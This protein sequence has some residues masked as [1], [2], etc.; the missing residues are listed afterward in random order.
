M[1]LSR[2]RFV[3]LLGA[4]TAASLAAP[5]AAAAASRGLEARFA[6]RG[7]DG[8]PGP[9]DDVIRLDSN[10]NPNGPGRA[11]LDALAGAAAGAHRYPFAAADAL[12][13]AVARLHGADAANV[14]VCCGSTDVLRACV[15][16]FA[17]PGRALVTAAPTFETPAA[18]AALAGA[19]VTAVP[20]RADLRLD[21][22]AMAAAA[23]RGAGLV[24][25]CNP[26]NPTGTVHG[27]DA[28]RALVE[29][30]LREA[31]GCAVVV[32]EA[33]HE[34]V[35]DS[36]YATAVPLA[37][38]HPRVVVARTFSKVYGLAGARVGYA[39]A[40]ADTMQA[41]APRALDIGVNA[42]G[43]AAALATLGD[44]AHLE[45]ERARNRAAR[46]YT[47]RFFA[48]AGYAPA[49]SEANFLMVDL[50]RDAGPFRAACRAAGVRVGRP[51]PPL[52]THARVTFGTMDEMRRATAVF[53]RALATA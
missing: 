53:R 39:V 30:V 46:E 2:R 13:A 44:A 24:Y 50:R 16:A 19:P 47:R 23:A 38:A 27:R 41:L 25:V 45:G 21:L 9:D 40:R 49:P 12:R 52:L 33:Y 6:A 36:A 34:Y 42:L 37:L 8:G 48:D 10:E 1:P 35:D 31:P 5:A 17:G 7:D 3:H 51:F 11:A 26:N 20:V 14:A 4:G 32:D 18:E 43:A 15:Q 29:R 28:V 22:D